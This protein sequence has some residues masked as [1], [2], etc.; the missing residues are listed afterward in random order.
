MRLVYPA[1]LLVSAAAIGYEI[2]LMRFL[3]IVQWHHFAYMIISLALFGY[4]ASGTAIALARRFVEPRFAAAMSASALLFSVTMIVAI[5]GAQRVS[6]NALEVLWNPA[7]FLGLAAIYLIFMLPFF[8]AAACIGLAFTCRGSFVERI[9]FFD[10]LGAGSGALIVIVALFRLSPQ[11][12]QVL[13]SL[14]ALTASLLVALQATARLRTLLI[15]LQVVAAGFIVAVAPGQLLDLRVSEY[16]ALSQTMQVADTEILAVR[17]SPFGL[18]T[19][20]DSPRIPFRFAP[21]LSF[22]AISTPGEQL[23][24]F[25][26]GDDMTVITRFDGDLGALR[27]LGEMTSALAYHLV[28][29]PSTLVLGAG[30]GSGVLQALYHGA[31]SVDAVE[32]NPQLVLL[33]AD[34]YADYAGHVLEDERVRLHVGEARGFVTGS[35]GHWDLIQLSL[36]DAFAS[37]GSGA[38]G[39]NESYLYTVEAISQYI[40]HLEPDG[41]LSITRWLRL[42]ARDSLK[43]VATVIRALRGQGVERPGDHLAVIRGWNTVTLLVSRAP[44]SPLQSQRLEAWARSLSFDTA[45]YPSMPSDQANRF[46]RLEGAPIYGG[47]TALLEDEAAFIDRY[48]FDIEPATDDRPYFFH[49]FRWAVLPEMIALGRQGGAGLIEWGYPVLIA[50]FVQAV[51]AG[52]L[53]IVL[54]LR[55]AGR[56]AQYSSTTVPG[57]YFFVLGLA[58]LFVEIAFIQ[59]FILLLH[60]PLYSVAV[61]LAGFLVFAGVGS[62]CSGKFGEL[63]SGRRPAAV[64]LA[65]AVIA[66]IVLVYL[67][68]LPALFAAW[69]SYPDFAKILLSLALIA[70]L[71]FFMGMPFP[72]ALA[73]LARKSVGFVPW[74][75]GINGFASVIAATLATLLAVEFGFSVVLLAAVALYGVAALLF[76][77][78]SRVSGAGED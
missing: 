36:L 46:N 54:P 9:Y 30:G 20:V 42:P 48:K 59:K 2:L 41:I 64:T 1:A 17:S 34:T 77:R 28:E 53:L 43:L 11:Y 65:A 23:G 35:K 12:A 62:A 32:L 55:L 19:V 58:F 31:R 56:R 24:V 7:Q 33:V 47:I 75:W 61:V 40:E 39:L 51:L 57:G 63:L 38:Q 70:P 60:Q 73:L 6:F 37:S 16:K 68:L 10:L 50:T 25:T 18:L 49:F 76:S 69:A 71:A 15:G 66:V 72:V 8:F 74:A 14:L 13:L 26:D 67:W 29:S 4:A 5:Y 78:A 21:G 27:Y 44:L 52:L 45:W 22:A 3:S